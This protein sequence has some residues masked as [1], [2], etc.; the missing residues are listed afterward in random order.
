MRLLQWILLAPF[1]R[2]S[3][4]KIG[5][6]W[7][8]R[9]SCSMCHAVTAEY[10]LCVLESALTVYLPLWSE[11]HILVVIVVVSLCR[12]FASTEFHSDVAQLLSPF[13]WIVTLVSKLPP[14]PPPYSSSPCHCLHPRARQLCL[15]WKS[16]DENK[17]EPLHVCFQ[18]QAVHRLLEWSG[19]AWVWQ[20]LVPSSE[21]FQAYVT[22]PHADGGNTLC[23][24]PRGPRQCCCCWATALSGTLMMAWHISCH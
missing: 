9:F 21:T 4:A 15:T 23:P 2:S 11:F 12:P 10:L 20:I 1:K 19:S 5:V 7:K 17:H 6:F 14:P 16:A 22:K 3:C 13:Q 18:T 8:P 24:R